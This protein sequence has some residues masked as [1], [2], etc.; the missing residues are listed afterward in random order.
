M[1]KALDSAKKIAVLAI[2]A[3]LLVAGKWALN[4]IPN[5]E[6][7]TLFCALFG[8][9]FGFAAV[10]PTTVFCIE[11]MLAFGVHTWV[12]DYLVHWN[13]IVCVFAALGKIRHYPMKK[14]EYVI[15]VFIGVFLTATYGV[16]TSTVDAVFACFYSDF[17]KFFTYFLTIYSRGVVFF[18]VHIV[19]NLVTF[20]VLFHPLRIL[21]EKLKEKVYV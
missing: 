9:V 12:V 19:C 14:I 13:A 16:F 2:M 17:T 18:V 15:P 5:V 8:Y 20:T 3:A 4:A 21:L 10:I 11:E 6:V 7:V 1:K